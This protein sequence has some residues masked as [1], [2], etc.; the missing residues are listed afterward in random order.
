[1]TF[2]EGV[3]AALSYC[4]FLAWLTANARAERMKNERNFLNNK[5]VTLQQAQ[6]K[7]KPRLEGDEW[8]RECGYE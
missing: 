2:L 6:K 3:L 7:N 4:M 1:M 5:C 8:K